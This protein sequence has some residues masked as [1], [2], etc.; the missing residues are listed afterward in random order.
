[1]VMWTK[2]EYYAWN[3]GDS[4]LPIKLVVFADFSNDYLLVS[5]EA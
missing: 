1:M 4:F 5:F 3:F 2:R